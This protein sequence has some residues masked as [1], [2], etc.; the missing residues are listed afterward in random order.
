MRILSNQLFFYRCIFHPM[1]TRPLSSTDQNTERQHT[2]LQ[3]YGKTFTILFEEKISAK[4]AKRPEL[5]KMLQLGYFCIFSSKS[6]H[7]EHNSL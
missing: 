1:F 5:Q 6:S 7:R 4:D 2:Q 3:E